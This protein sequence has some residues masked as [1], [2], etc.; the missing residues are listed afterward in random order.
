[1]FELGIS[2]GTF[3]PI[4]LWHTVV[5]DCAR[6]QYGLNEVLFIPNGNPVHKT[7]VLDK[8]IRLE[9]VQA[10]IA[11]NP[12]FK[13]SRVEVDREGPSFTVDTLRAL[14]DQYGDNV[15]LN[16]IMGVDNIHPDSSLP[17]TRW[18]ESEEVLRLC[19][20]L[21]GPRHMEL[22]DAEKVAAMLPASANFALIDCPTS[23][24][25]STLVRD[26]VKAGKSIRHLVSPAV[27]E[28]ITKH[29]LYTNA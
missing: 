2:A 23:T 4:H 7:G 8:E 15:R 17:V 21:I 13:A 28:I 14:K 19:R 9:M 1:M 26:R 16:L 3:N 12:F 11:E 10:A 18:R 5:A 24:L 29:R 20:L 25:S 27:F 6:A 22:A